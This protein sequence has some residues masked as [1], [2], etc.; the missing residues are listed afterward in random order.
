MSGNSRYVIPVV[1]AATH[2]RYVKKHSK[3]PRETIALDGGTS[4]L[5]CICVSATSGNKIEK[6]KKKR[7]NFNRIQSTDI[8]NRATSN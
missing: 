2:G 1:V 4:H 8:K 3:S 7:N 5:C 6:R